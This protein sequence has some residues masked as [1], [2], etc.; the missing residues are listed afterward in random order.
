MKFATVAKSLA[1]GFALVASSAFAATKDSLQISHSVTVNGTTLKAGDYK[2]E[3][4]GSGSSVELSIMQGK[5]VLAK[6]SAQI[7]ELKDPAP[8]NAAVTLKNDDGTSSLVGLRF[9]G[10]KVALDLAGSS[11]GMQGRSSK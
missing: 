9:E 4:Q 8:Y 7:V 1:L 6:A 2:V 3:W 11:D 5:R 10:E